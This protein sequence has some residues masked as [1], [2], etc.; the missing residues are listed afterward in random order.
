MGNSSG[1][2]TE[3]AG[4]VEALRAALRAQQLDG[5]IVPRADEHLGEYVPDSAARLA[6]ISGFTGSAG[7]AIVLLDRAAVWSDGRYTLQLEAE[8]D[9]ALWERLH[10]TE[11]KPED[12]LKQHAAGLRIGYDPWL[13]SPAALRRFAGSTLV[14]VAANPIDAVWPGRPAPPLA[15]AVPHDVAFA[16]EA[17]AAKRA[18]LGQVLAAAGQ[19]TAI[20]TDPVSLAWLFNLR[21][22]DVEFTPIALGFALLHADGKA[23]LF[24]APEKLAPET[25]AHL[26]DD[27]AVLAPDALPA[28]IAALAGKTVRY[29]PASM[30]AWFK[31]AL[32]AAGAS[33]AEAPDPVALPRACKNDTEQQGSRA[34]HLRDGVA[35]ARFLGWLAAAAPGGGETEMSAASR[36]LAER[37]RGVLFKG[38]SFPAI[39]GAGEHG[40]VIHY[41]VSP[42]SDR[43][44]KPDELYLIDSGGQYLDG[45]TDITRTVWTGPGAPPEAVMQAYTRVL[46]GHIAL[47]MTV[48]PVGVAGPHL[49]ALARY[50]L[51]QAGLDYDHGTGH[52]VGAYLSVHEG[53]ASIARTAKPVPL[54]PGMILSNE[55]GYY[56]PGVYGI[57]LENLL[58][59]QHAKFPD[60]KRQ[61]LRFETLT[62]APFDR[63]LIVTHMLPGPLIAWLDA[64]HAGSSCC[65]AGSCRRPGRPTRWL[66]WPPPRHRCGRILPLTSPEP[67]LQHR[68][69]NRVLMPTAAPPCACS[70]PSIFR[71][72]SRKS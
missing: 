40:A 4:R 34:A 43:P 28:A 21:G 17:A 49:D 8:T 35:M 18:R 65:W 22:A 72:R 6:F 55:P 7:L 13:S 20:L 60:T 24:M 16:G 67:L 51:W 30:A 42:E 46:L 39:S 62:L 58:L 63:R 68:A 37:G 33:I 31:T 2:T 10:M 71:G 5:F 29:D 70:L 38:E 50:Q 27:V 26:G 14:A 54:A 1:M 48:F 3:H 44:L 52:G 57:R 12:W 9:A 64:Y 36:L 32:T 19:D 69:T 41:R 45:T 56:L 15:P 23:A 25:L 53:P 59:V 11:A 66:G 61:F 47:A